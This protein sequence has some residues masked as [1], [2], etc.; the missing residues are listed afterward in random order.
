MN[1]YCIGSLNKINSISR[2]HDYYRR[3]IGSRPARIPV[4]PGLPPDG[5]LPLE[6]P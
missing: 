1:V 4:N 2:Y 6:V 5:G 3:T